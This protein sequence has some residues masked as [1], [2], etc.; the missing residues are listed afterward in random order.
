MAVGQVALADSHGPCLPAHPHP[1]LSLF[2][3]PFLSLCPSFSLSLF[4]S[5]SP[6]SPFLRQSLSV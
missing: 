5:F 1:F 6:F 4:F 3:P 2:S